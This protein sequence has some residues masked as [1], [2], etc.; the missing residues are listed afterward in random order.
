MRKLVE[1]RHNL[2]WR[3]EDLELGYSEARFDNGRL[4]RYAVSGRVARKRINTLVTK[5]PTT[6]MWLES[7]KKDDFF[8]DIGANVGTYTVYAS[9]MTYCHVAAFEPEA[10][11]Y[12]ELN[13]NIYLNKLYERVR[14]YCCAVSNRDAVDTLYLSR[15][16]PAYSHHDF[17]ENRWEGPVK[18]IAGDPARRPRQGCMARSLDSAVA[19]GMPVPSHIKIDVDG[20]EW[21]VIEGA[22]KTLENPAVR[23]VLVETDFKIAK[24]VALMDWFRERGWQTSL[25]QLTYDRN[26]RI[27]EAELTRRIREQ[28][29]GVN[30]IYFRDPAYHVLFR[31]EI[32]RATAQ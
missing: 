32:A 5:E 18:A 9:V 26:G 28:N 12:A 19:C 15:F 16:A 4:L 6:L 22:K 3:A 17:G 21:Q 14:G 29:G 10:L 30:V 11:N 23:S 25:D 1:V 20:L 7:F 2:V 8:V 24:S 31:E 13:K 27:D